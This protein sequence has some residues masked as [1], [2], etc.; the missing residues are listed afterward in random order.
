[1][2]ECSHKRRAAA[3]TQT[4]RAA[5]GQCIVED[6][7]V[8]SRQCVGLMPIRH[9]VFASHQTAKDATAQPDECIYAADAYT[10]LPSMTAGSRSLSNGATEMWCHSGKF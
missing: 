9:L 8:H 4:S 6:D 3:S 10:P 7:L 1:M 2:S 5:A